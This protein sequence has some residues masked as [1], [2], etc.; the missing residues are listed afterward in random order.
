MAAKGFGT[1]EWIASADEYNFK[2]G[3]GT[4][5]AVILD[6][7]SKLPAG[8]KVLDIG[9]SGGRLADFVRRTGHHVTGIDYI[10]VPGVRDRTDNFFK[11]D[12]VQGIPPEI[13]SGFDVII[14]G[15]VIE[16]LPRPTQT[17]R[18]IERLLRPGGQVILS[19]PNFGH[20]YPRTR[21]LFG[22]WGYDRRGILDDTHLR[23]FSR[24]TLRR[25]VS[26]AGFD[27]LEEKTTGLPLGVVTEG[28]GWKIKTVRGIDRGLVRLRPTFF[29]Y[30][31]VMRLT[32]HSEEALVV[33]GQ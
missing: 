8:Q 12:L 25:L 10:E 23:F 28:D 33:E 30:Q 21:A 26:R 11:V 32:P 19:V 13:G 4:S 15:D 29:G 6:M 5:H 31:F 7:I 22:V 9:C 1:A 3:D 18:E 17:M 2:D 20:W 14:A 16:H 27:I 24:R